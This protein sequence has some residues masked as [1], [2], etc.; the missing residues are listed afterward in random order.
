M[1]KEK[2]SKKEVR[3]E[4]VEKRKTEKREKK[5]KKEKKVKRKEETL[6]QSEGAD[7]SGRKENTPAKRQKVDSPFLE[8]EDSDSD[9][10]PVIITS[11]TE[12]VQAKSKDAA[13]Y[14]ALR[15]AKEFVEEDFVDDEEEDEDYDDEE[16]EEEK[17]KGKVAELCR[18]PLASAWLTGDC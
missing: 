1:G 12:N 17:E 16:E 10:A 18:A 7:G 4:T 5:G 9:A 2:K 3:G 11:E 15:A 13:L 6:G 14:Q 8:G